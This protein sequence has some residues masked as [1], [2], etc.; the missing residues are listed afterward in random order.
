MGFSKSSSHEGVRRRFK[1]RWSYVFVVFWLAAL[2][3]SLYLVP[4]TNV[5]QLAFE[6]LFNAS[7]FLFLVWGIAGLGRRSNA[8]RAFAVLILL[9]LVG[10]AYANQQATVHDVSLKGARSVYAAENAYL[11]NYAASFATTT[12]N[13]ATIPQVNVTAS[14]IPPILSTTSV[15]SAAAASSSASTSSI[16]PVSGNWLVDD[17]SFVGGSAKI[18]TPPNY[19]TLLNFTL[20]LINQDRVSADLSPVSLSPV[21]SG[22][23]HADSMAYFGYL[24]HWDTQGYKPYMRYTLLGGTGAVAENAGMDSCTT[25]PPSNSLVTLANCSLQH[26]ENGIANS[27][28]QM[29]NNDATC[30]DNGHRDNI[31]DQT[32][33]RVSLGIS[34]NETTGTVYLVEDFED[35]YLQLNQPVQS[36]P[37]QIQIVGTGSTETPISQIVVYYDPIPTPMTIQQLDAT[38]AYDPGTFVGGVLP[39]CNAG[40]EYFPNAVNV[41]AT[42]WETTSDSVDFSF[43]MANFFVADGPGVYTIYVLTGSSTADAMLTYSVFNS[44]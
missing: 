35:S 40:C 1:I 36:S 34:Y 41:Y 4:G 3:L 32:H 24:S 15:S 33:N 43:S 2:G 18:D 21:Q 13:Q 11:A 17:P 23:Q 26:I 20:A 44:G 14:A 9:I 5:V 22:Q 27:E 38:F 12:T 10:M 39:P 7:L 29:M 31:L 6:S 19:Q 30:C 42:T 37:G 28:W 25:S 16:A 8:R